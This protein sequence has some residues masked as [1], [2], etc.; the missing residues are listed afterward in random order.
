MNFSIVR[1]A[2]DGPEH[3]ADGIDAQ[4]KVDQRIRSRKSDHRYD[5]DDV[6]AN[7]TYLRSLARSVVERI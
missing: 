6:F 3:F 5:E 1:P 7:Y 2:T 4:D